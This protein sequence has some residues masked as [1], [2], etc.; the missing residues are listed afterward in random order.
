MSALYI[1]VAI[2]Q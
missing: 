1:P 2:S